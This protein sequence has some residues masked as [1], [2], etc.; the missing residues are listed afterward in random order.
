M[1]KV[2]AIVT[3]F[4][5]EQS[6]VD[7][8]RKLEA[9]MPPPAEILVHVDGGQDAIVGLVKKEF[10]RIKILES[11][12]RLG[13]GGARNLLIKE[14]SHEWIASFDDDSRPWDEDYFA[15]IDHAASQ[16]PDAAVLAAT[17]I[18]RGGAPTPSQ[19]VDHVADF[20]GCGCVYRR[21]AFLETT[22]FVP[23][24]VAYAMEEVDLAIRLCADGK[25]ILRCHGLRILHDTDMTHRA[26]REI[27]AASIANIA[28]HAF[29]RYPLIFWPVGMVQCLRKIVSLIHLGWTSGIAEGILGIPRHLWRHRHLRNP[30][31]SRDFRAYQQL[32]HSPHP[33]LAPDR[34]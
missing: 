17:I 3:A 31:S 4:E 22:G 24:P 33:N 19:Q 10:P 28:L 30:I 14:A 6:L 9:C 8:L 23:L 12:P 26:R 11:S 13:P 1:T 15:R 20:V 32:R 27:T 21:S 16:Y 5:R 18:E 25:R 29:L 34:V 2:S 7:T